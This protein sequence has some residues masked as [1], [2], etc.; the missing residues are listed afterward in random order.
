MLASFIGAKEAVMTF[1]IILLVTII[2]LDMAALRWSV[3]SIDGIDSPEWERRR[4][5]SLLHTKTVVVPR[6]MAYSS[7]Y[8]LN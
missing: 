5:W 2:L 8:Y 3:S 4:Q 6:Y 1:F 7:K